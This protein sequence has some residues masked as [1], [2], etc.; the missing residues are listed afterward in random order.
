MEAFIITGGTPLVGEVSISGAKNVALKACVAALLTDEPIILKNVPSIR[1]VTYMLEVL[2]NLG[3]SVDMSANTLHI[4]NGH[5]KKLSVDL[6][7]GARLRT[8]TLVL[9]PLLARFGEAKI[10]NPGGCRIGARPID[11]HIDGLRAM[12]AQIRYDSSDGYFHSKATNLHGAHIKFPKNTH[13]G[14]ET[15]VLAAVLAKGQ[16][17][18]E[19]AAEEVEIDN[20]I[21]L[22]NK[23]GARISRTSLRTIVIDGVNSLHGLEFS[24]MPDRNEEVTFAIVAALTHGEVTVRNSQIACLA[25]FLKPFTQAGGEYQRIDDQTTK[26]WARGKTTATNVTTGPYPAFMTDWQAPWAVFMTQANGNSTIHETVFESRFSYVGELR[27]MGSKIDFYDPKVKNPREFYNFNW[28]DRP[29]GYHQGIKIHGPARLHNAVLE[30]SDLRAG[31]TLVLAGLVS[32]G[33]SYIR[34]IEQIDRGYE[35]IDEKLKSL[36][37]NIERIRE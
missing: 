12:G 2:Q 18:L 9:G 8:S 25:A 15:L 21:L 10:P 26:Y 35:K 28:N 32:K 3:A 20:L 30:I 1:D 4:Q 7:V 33:E 5:V 13:T 37:A 24:I 19:N 31:A 6:E 17:V 11:R 16:T 36:G 27:K 23:M 22:L 14:T 34:G 29:K